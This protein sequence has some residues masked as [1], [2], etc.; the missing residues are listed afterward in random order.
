MPDE[1]IETTA[2]VVRDAREV[3][4]RGADEN[5][6]REDTNNLLDTVKRILEGENATVKLQGKAYVTADTWRAIG[7]NAGA[8]ACATGIEW[9]EDPMT[10]KPACRAHVE[11][12]YDERLVGSGFG[13]CSS[14]EQQTLYR[15]SKKGEK[16]TVVDRW[17]DAHAVEAMAQTRATGR[18]LRNAVGFL[19]D[20]VKGYETTPYEE[21]PPME[22]E[23][24]ALQAAARP[25]ARRRRQSQAEPAEEQAEVVEAEVVEAEAEAAPPA[26]PPPAKPPTPPHPESAEAANFTQDASVKWAYDFHKN[27]VGSGR[28]PPLSTDE[29]F[30]VYPGLHALSELSNAEQQAAVN[31]VKELPVQLQDGESVTDRWLLVLPKGG[32]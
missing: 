11:V 18:A 17:E 29:W 13:L 16:G 10:K 27:A 26:E 3:L 30:L 32:D 23:P 21:M 8:F 9:I 14:G 20:A 7:A 31:L 6:R 4:V 25:G 15:D 1:P 28:L 22:N 5:A 19:V 2:V 24:A 12:R